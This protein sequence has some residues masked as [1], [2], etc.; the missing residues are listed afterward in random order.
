MARTKQT[1]RKSELATAP[2]KAKKAK[3]PVGGG[4][5]K[6]PPP[7]LKKPHRFRPGTV[8]IRE[9]RRFQRDTNPLFKVR[10]MY[11]LVKEIIQDLPNGEQIRTAR[12]AIAALMA[13]SEDEMVKHFMSGQ[14]AALHANRITVQ[15]RD[16]QLGIRMRAINPAPICGN[17]GSTDK[18][19]LMPQRRVTTVADGAT[20]RKKAEKATKAVFKTK[21]IEP[22]TSNP[23]TTST[24]PQS[25]AKQ[26]PKDA[27][28]K[29]KTKKTKPVKTDKKLVPI[30]SGSRTTSPVSSPKKAKTKKLA[31]TEEEE[32]EEFE[33]EDAFDA[34][35]PELAEIEEGDEIIEPTTTT[36]KKKAVDIDEWST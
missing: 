29:K 3:K 25:P 36:T 15:P 18:R 13:A 5:K 9:I 23:V 1:A 35:A 12:S 22:V 17:I 6:P 10:P 24:P 8:A 27:G 33:A 4:T 30:T 28:I 16:L 2:K 20:A 32:E 7:G 19:I 21:K 11:R 14:E 34:P 31:A 26:K